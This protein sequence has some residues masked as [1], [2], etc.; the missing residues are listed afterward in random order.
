L[1][2]DVATGGSPSDDVTLSL[3]LLFMIALFVVPQGV[4][5]RAK[6]ATSHGIPVPQAITELY[7][8][9]NT[10]FK[11]SSAALTVALGLLGGSWSSPPGSLLH[12]LSPVFAF[13]T[14]LFM[15]LAFSAYYWRDF[16]GKV[17]KEDYN[18][19]PSWGVLVPLLFVSG[20]TSVISIYS[21]VAHWED[22]IAFY[23][24]SILLS[25]KVA[26]SLPNEGRISPKFIR[27]DLARL[28]AAR[29]KLD[30]R[31]AWT[32]D[33]SDKY[34]DDE[35]NARIKSLQTEISEVDKKRRRYE[36]ALAEYHSIVEDVIGEASAYAKR[37]ASREDIVEMPKSLTQI[38]ASAAD[39][40]S[41]AV[42]TLSETPDDEPKSYLASKKFNEI[43]ET[44]TVINFHLILSALGEFP[45]MVTKVT[46]QR[47]S[48][49]LD[50]STYENYGLSMVQVAIRNYEK[51]E[52]AW[53]WSRAKNLE[54]AIH[55][56]SFIQTFWVSFERHCQVTRQRIDALESIVSADP[57]SEYAQ[58]LPSV[59]NN[60]EGLAFKLR[61]AIETRA[62]AKKARE[63]VEPY[64]DLLS[65]A[66][67]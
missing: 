37:R 9:F 10:G 5:R 17:L 62:L 44:A 31:L 24:P 20:V 53:M 23:G 33:Q 16:L 52:V 1:A 49:E 64:R 47:L 28:V 67:G 30:I 43:K 51:A 11:P 40:V 3:I 22:S 66:K 56:F 25:F 57:E 27:A 15:V 36:K 63:L 41:R 14:N 46:V 55:C 48:K 60:N 26:T 7:A 65:T 6:R 2:L 39:A 18:Q 59:R 61:K 13:A 54:S 12:N 29:A 21:G 35:Y 8:W 34:T 45:P 38:D 19:T 32:R 50:R 42:L 58:L 4:I